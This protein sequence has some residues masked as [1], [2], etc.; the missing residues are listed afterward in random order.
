MTLFSKRQIV[1]VVDDDPVSVEMLMTILANEYTVMGAQ[2]GQEA[3][4]ILSTVSP[5]LILLDIVMP[6]MD[7]YA[8]FQR[9][10]ELPNMATTPVLFLTCMA[11]EAHEYRGLEM[12]AADY[13][14]K[15]Y[16]PHLVRLRVKNQLRMHQTR[17]VCTQTFNAMSDL[18]FIID[19]NYRIL[20]I[21]QSALDALKITREQ[22]LGAAC[23]LCMHGTEQ[24]PE[25][26]PQSKTLSDNG[27]HII[28]V[29]VEQLGEQFQVTTTPIFDEQGQYQATLH[30]AHDITELKQ[31]EESLEQA[32]EFAEAA[33]QAK[34]EFLANMS[35]EIRTPMNG[36]IGMAQ[37]L[38]LT[39]LTPKQEEYLDA[40]ETSAENLL[41][42]ISDILDLSKVEA[43]K[44][45][46]EHTD[47]S[48][49][50]AINDVNSTQ[51]SRIHQKKLQLELDLSDELPELVRGDQLRYKQILLN[52]LG[53]AIKFTEQGTITVSARVLER[54]NQTARIRTTVSDT[55]IGIPIKV[56][57]SIFKPFSQADSS[58]TRRFGGTGLGLTIC[59][60]LAELMG[61]TILVESEPGKGSRFHFDL[62][63]IVA[64]ASEA[65]AISTPIPQGPQLTILVAEDNETNLRIAELMLLKLGHRVL[66]CGDGQAALDCWRQGDIDVI[67]MDIFMPVMNGMEAVEQI[68]REEETMAHH[69][70][71]IALTANAMKGTEEKLVAAGF[72]RYLTKP[73]KIRDLANELV[74]VTDV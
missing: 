31:Y 4:T 8:L 44:V 49:I 72:D 25:F 65:A 14:S 71:I 32:K 23:H 42:L 62:P 51:I 50:K 64:H 59:R 38:H 60:K 67:L 66:S 21:N 28:Q 17:H 34:S 33:N 63:F 24:P 47:F 5:D 22:A 19:A 74:R 30:V 9:I 70:P 6:E 69:T 1:L 48:L 57:N 54:Q 53:N 11:E 37:L 2:S 55:G 58:T 26:C 52:L 7:G 10:K 46:L 39:E 43:G 13:I 36:V 56:Q 27:R 18:I 15:P 45:E 35:H 61:G 20:D 12:G 68:R 29:L 41:D 73:V 3:L 40:I 16:N